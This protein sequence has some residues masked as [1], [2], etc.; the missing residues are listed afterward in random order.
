MLTED[1]GL[2]NN[3]TQG[4]KVIVRAVNVITISHEEHKVN[5]M[6]AK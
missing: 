3:N 4:E 5:K 1:N 6:E 2:K